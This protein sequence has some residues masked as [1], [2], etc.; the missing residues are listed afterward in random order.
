MAK[1]IARWHQ[2]LKEI[3]EN[4]WENLVGPQINP[5]FRWKWLN[6]LEISGSVCAQ[7]GWQPFH[8]GLWR[9][10]IPIAIAPLYLKSHSY[11]EFIFDQVF[12]KL[13]Q[14]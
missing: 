9:E 8:L 10:D 1:L 14:N 11:G 6:A 13:A 3:P 7:Q 5:F 12:A 2:S 4:H